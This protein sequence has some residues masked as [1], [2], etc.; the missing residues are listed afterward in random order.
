MYEQSG[1]LHNNF[2]SLK[3]YFRALQICIYSWPTIMNY[4]TYRFMFN[5]NETTQLWSS[6]DKKEQQIFCCD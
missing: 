4:A 5:F 1:K 3:E 6:T 2:G